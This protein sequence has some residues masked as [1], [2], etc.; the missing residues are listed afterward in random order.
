MITDESRFCALSNK[1]LGLIMVH[2]SYVHL[3]P[4]I[5]RFEQYFKHA[6]RANFLPSASLSLPAFL[7]IL[8][9]EE[10]EKIL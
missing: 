5:L 7:S 4:C 1:S 8:N 10:E 6:E 9:F 2:Q 3:L